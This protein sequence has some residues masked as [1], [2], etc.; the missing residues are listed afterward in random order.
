MFYEINTSEGIRSFVENF[1][2]QNGKQSIYRLTPS[3]Q[4]QVMLN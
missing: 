4:N 2:K 3:E 1:A